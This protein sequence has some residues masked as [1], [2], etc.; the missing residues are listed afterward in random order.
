[1]TEEFERCRLD[2]FSKLDIRDGAI[3][4]GIYQQDGSLVPMTIKDTQFNRL[5]VSWVQIHDRS[6]GMEA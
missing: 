5:F 2:D 4:F 3:H 6:G 1:M